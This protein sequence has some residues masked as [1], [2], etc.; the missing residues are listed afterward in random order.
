[1]HQQYIRRDT[2]ELSG[3]PKSV[4]DDALED[5]VIDLFKES[6]VSVNRQ[7]LKKLDI[8][9][10]HRKKD[11][12]TTIVKV[13]NR[14]FAREALYKSKAFRENNTYGEQTKIYIN[15]SFCPEFGFLNFAVRQAK[16][17]NEI[18]KWKVRNGVTSVQM[19]VDDNWVQI[20]HIKDLENLGIRIPN[21]NRRE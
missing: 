20:G 8:Q 11:K 10:V 4:N 5:A 17:V 15:D 3:I 1:M 2:I 12:Q 9:A 13:V 18:F 14:K 19:N 21:R 7:P 6:K 16:K